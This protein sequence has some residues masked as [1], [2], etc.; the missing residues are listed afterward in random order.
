MSSTMTSGCTRAM[1][2]RSCGSQ[3]FAPSMS[4]P[5]VGAMNVSSCCTVGLRNSGAVSRMNSFQKAPASSSSPST[6][7]AGGAR[8]TRSSSNPSGAS[9]P[10]HDASAANTTRCPR[11]RRTSPMPTHWLVGP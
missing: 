11:L 7:S 5:Q 8:S 4:A 2:S 3:Y 6:G 1:I 9:F 10:F